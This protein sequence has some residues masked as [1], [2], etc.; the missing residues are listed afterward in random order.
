MREGHETAG[1]NGY[2]V[3]DERVVFEQ[4]GSK[5]TGTGIIGFEAD[6]GKFTSVWMDSRRTQL[7]LRQS[8]DRFNGEEIVLYSASLT[9]G[10]EDGR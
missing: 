9:S 3:I 8:P 4:G 10:K 7:S 6:S 5:T 1:R 2:R